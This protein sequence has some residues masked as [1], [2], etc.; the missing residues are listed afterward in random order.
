MS[1]PGDH[2]GISGSW[3]SC[4][5]FLNSIHH[6]LLLRI[7]YGISNTVICFQGTHQRNKCWMHYSRGAQPVACDLKPGQCMPMHW[8]GGSAS[9]DS[10]QWS[11]DP[12][13]YSIRGHR[14]GTSSRGSRHHISH[15]FL[16]SAGSRLRRSDTKCTSPGTLLVAWKTMPLHTLHFCNGHFST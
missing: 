14:A 6:I 8:H 12:P 2:Q 9:Q 16:C 4:L 11:I 13:S 5:S 1:H 10:D 15:C 3:T 7:H